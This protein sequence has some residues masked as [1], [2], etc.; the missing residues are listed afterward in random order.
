MSQIILDFL[1]RSYF[2]IIYGIALVVSLKTYRKYF[3][4]VFKFLPLIIAYTFVNELLGYFIRYYPEFSFFNNQMYSAFNDVIYNLYDLVFF[5]YFYYAY[6]K[7]AS[8]KTYKVRIAW[9]SSFAVLA[10]LVSCFF[11]NPMD[12]MLYYAYSFAS[13]VLVFSILLNIIEKKET[14]EKVLDPYNLVFWINLS[15]I[16]FY[17]ISPILLIIGYTN[18]EIW[19]L[20]NLRLI[21]RIAIII[22]YSLL[23]I[24]L[25]VSRKFSF[26]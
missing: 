4:T 16:F 26:R 2:V 13:L 21:L 9:A 12:T 19:E 10:Y 23:T 17:S 20:Y 24:G 1:H 14:N 15:L 6:W 8:K 7:L 3:E 5:P 25:L 18:L 11:Q 22:M